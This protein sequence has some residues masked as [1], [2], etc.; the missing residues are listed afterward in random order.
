MCTNTA[1]ED[2]IAK[3]LII[4]PEIIITVFVALSG[5]M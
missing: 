3:A 1:I 5:A 4:V 2:A